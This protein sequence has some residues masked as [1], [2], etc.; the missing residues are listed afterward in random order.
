MAE[1]VSGNGGYIEVR[2]AGSSG[3]YTRYDVKKWVL[4]TTSRLT[5]NTHSGVTATNFEEVV[6]HNEWSAEI[7]LDVLNFPS[8]G[9]LG[10][11]KVDIKFHVGDTADFFDLRGTSNEVGEVTDDNAED[12]VRVMASGKGGSLV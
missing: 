7:P 2:A 12:I 9:P 1:Y 11:S 10:L 6:P 3:S 5:E 8:D 4:R